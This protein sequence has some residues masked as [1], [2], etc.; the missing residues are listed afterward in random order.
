ML[1][2]VLLLLIPQRRAVLALGFES[3]AAL[4]SLV[5][6]TSTAELLSVT[7]IARLP[8]HIVGHSHGHRVGDG[9]RGTEDM[10]DEFKNERRA[11]LRETAQLRTVPADGFGRV[12]VSLTS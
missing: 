6:D 10:G 1:R 3:D 5:T 7:A 12:P 9:R 2:R 11:R 4:A 8:D